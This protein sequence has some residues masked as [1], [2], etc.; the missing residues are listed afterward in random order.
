MVC[1]I[2]QQG[3]LVTINNGLTKMHDHLLSNGHLTCVEWMDKDSV[4]TQ[5]FIPKS[6]TDETKATLRSFST[7]RYLRMPVMEPM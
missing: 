2:R 1:S 7:I 3:E 5:Y 4:I 6:K